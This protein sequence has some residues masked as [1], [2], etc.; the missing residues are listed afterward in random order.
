[1]KIRQGES[2]ICSLIKDAMRTANLKEGNRLRDY[3]NHMNKTTPARPLNSMYLLFDID[4]DDRLGHNVWTIEPTRDMSEKVVIYLHGGSYK[5]NFLT[6]HWYFIT[7]IINQLKVRVIA[8]DYPLAPEYNVTHVFDMMLALYKQVIKDTDPQHISIIGD[9]AG[10]GMTLALG[11]YL[12]EKGLPQPE[13]L[14]LLSPCVD[15]TMSNPD[16]IQLDDD[17][18]LLNIDSIKQ[19][20]I[21]YAGPLETTNYLVSPLYGKLE[22][23]A[24]ISCYVGT[25]DL[26]VAD[27]RKLNEK[28]VELGIDFTYHEY[29]GLFHV[30]MLYP[31]PEAGEIRKEIIDDLKE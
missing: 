4:V 20:G 23:L 24:P 18:P 6:P 19:A 13:Q 31:T 30:G 17:D 10:G 22:G 12:L 9:S 5:Y 25:N 27:C 11:Q 3:F 21:E 2:M 28:A 1:M 8:P 16:I 26:L 14:I 7:E 15:V 29:E